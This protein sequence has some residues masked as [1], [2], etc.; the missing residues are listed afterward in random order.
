MRLESLGLTQLSQLFIP[1]HEELILEVSEFSTG[2]KSWFYCPPIRMTSGFLHLR[3][4]WTGSAKMRFFFLGISI[5]I[6]QF[7]QSTDIPPEAAFSK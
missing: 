1:G 3:W 7:I 5:S 4:M 6:Y 2:W